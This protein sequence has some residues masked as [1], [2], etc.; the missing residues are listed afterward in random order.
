MFLVACLPFLFS[1]PSGIIQGEPGAQAQ[2]IT[3]HPSFKKGA[4]LSVVSRPGYRGFGG[5]FWEWGGGAEALGCCVA[6][7][8]WLSLSPVSDK[9]FPPLSLQCWST[10]RI[11]H[12]PMYFVNAQF[13]HF[14][15]VLGRTQEPPC[16]GGGSIHDL[17]LFTETSPTS[18]PWDHLPGP[19]PAWSHSPHS[20]F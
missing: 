2:L 13:P 6:L 10:G 3:F 1:S 11:A 4:L 9:T 16:G 12:I 5:G 7:P 18:A 20:H 19:P 14:S 17:P 15:P 8:Y